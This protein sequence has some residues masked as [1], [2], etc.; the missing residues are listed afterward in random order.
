[1]GPL[2]KESGDLVARD[3][4]KVEALS[5]FFASVFTVRSSSHA[6]QVPE[7]KGRDWEH[8]EV[9][10]VGEDQVRDQLKNLKVH[11]LWDLMRYVH[12]SWGNWQ[13]K[14][15]SHYPSYLRSCGSL[16]EFPLTGRGGT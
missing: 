6:A 11:K 9:P 13:L 12:E 8:E 1:M 4:E 3:M 16:V 15:L 7:D 5:D 10:S 14:L 2:Q